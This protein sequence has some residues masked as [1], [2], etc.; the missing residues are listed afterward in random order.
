MY[1]RPKFKSWNSK[2]CRKNISVS[3]CKLASCHFFFKVIQSCLTLCDP[4]DHTV[5]GILQA[6]I[7][8]WVAFPFSK[9]SSNPGLPYCRQILYQLS[10]KGSPKL[11]E[12]VAYSFSSRSFQP[13]N[14]TGLSCIASGFFT[15]WIIRE[16]QSISKYFEVSP[17]Q[18]INQNSQNENLITETQE[19]RVKTA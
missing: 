8:E 9:G 15:Y 11:L 14:W 16:A 6:R 13:R 18:T 2:T 7:L 1:Q 3:L 5:H 10:H 17:K 12:W 4:M 19:E